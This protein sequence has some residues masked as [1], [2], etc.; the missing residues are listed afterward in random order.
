MLLFKHVKTEDLSDTLI[1]NRGRSTHRVAAL[2]L[3]PLLL[4]VGLT[5]AAYSSTI[6]NHA[7]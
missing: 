3:P 1:K 4:L 2:L 5:V 6:V 7:L